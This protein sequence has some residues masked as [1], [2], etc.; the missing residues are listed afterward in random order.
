[1][2]ITYINDKLFDVKNTHDLPF[3][4]YDNCTF[5]GLNFSQLD[6]SQYIFNDC[7]FDNCNFSMTKV[8]QTAFRNVHFFECKIMGVLFDECNPFGIRLKFTDTSINNCTFTNLHL[9]KTLFTNCEIKECDFSAANLSESKFT[10]CQLPDSVFERTNLEKVDF[11]T[12]TNFRIDPEKN[13]MRKSRFSKEEL[14][15]L[16][17]KYNLDIEE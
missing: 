11:R 13:K 16:L 15:G 12:A 5:K 14:G 2:A 8:Q 9:T 6:I 4:E 17:F 7:E 1:M 10:N 3:G